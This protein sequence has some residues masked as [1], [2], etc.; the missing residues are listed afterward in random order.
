MDI[1]YMQNLATAANSGHDCDETG[2][3]HVNALA[4]FYTRQARG[5][6]IHTP[7]EFLFEAP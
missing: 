7:L 2:L 1:N 5:R 4:R 6:R 3:A